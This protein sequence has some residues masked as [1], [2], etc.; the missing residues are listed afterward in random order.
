MR[1][2]AL[3]LG[4]GRVLDPPSVESKTRTTTTT[5]STINSK[6][7]DRHAPVTDHRVMI[8]CRDRGASTLYKNPAIDR[9]A[10]AVTG[11]GTA[12][13]RHPV[14]CGP[15]IAPGRG[16]GRGRGPEKRREIETV[17]TVETVTVTVTASGRVGAIRS[18]NGRGVRRPTMT[19]TETETETADETVTRI[20]IGIIV[21]EVVIAEIGG[22][23]VV[24]TTETMLATAAGTRTETVTVTE[25][26]RI[27]MAKTSTT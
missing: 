21:T 8:L 1:D 20:V 5:K 17:E 27:V 12:S 11:T 3:G 16:R 2:G 7:T 19:K 9:S 22:A 24:I 14:L 26:S 13:A 15:A 6:T 4:L 10:A 23:P 18:P 25:T